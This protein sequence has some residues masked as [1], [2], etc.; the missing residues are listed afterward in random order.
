MRVTM[1][2]VTKGCATR[3]TLAAMRTAATSGLSAGDPLL[4]APLLSQLGV[5][6]D[7][8]GDEERLAS[9]PSG[10]GAPSLAWWRKDAQARLIRHK[11]SVTQ[12]RTGLSR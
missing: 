11:G 6:F 10:P 5:Y 4:R 8:L 3:G 7:Y 12:T 1:T 9:C 2:A